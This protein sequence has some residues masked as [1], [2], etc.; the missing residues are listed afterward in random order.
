MSTFDFQCAVCP[1]GQYSLFGG[2]SN[3]SAG[4]ATNFNCLPCP[5]GGVCI[6]GV[7]TAAPGFWGAASV[8][9]ST[10]SFTVCSAGTCCD[11][12]A[13]PCV[14]MSSCAGY[15]DGP[16]CGDC[17]PGYVVPIG[18]TQCVPQAACASDKPV[19]WAM[20]AV[21]ELVSAVSQLTVVSGTWLP[22]PA[23]PNGKMKLA[24]YF[25]QVNTGAT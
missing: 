11:G 12:Q 18:S 2:F 13:W 5:V 8:P 17:R 4:T 25:T 15:R 19:L 22:S 7:V 3:G 23:P 24:I 21:V 10:V 9:P 6:D 1:S 20:V 14:G 16:L